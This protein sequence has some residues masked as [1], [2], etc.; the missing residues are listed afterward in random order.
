MVALAKV[1]SRRL[2]R[3]DAFSSE[4]K[5]PFWMVRRLQSRARLDCLAKR[6]FLGESARLRVSPMDGPR[7]ERIRVRARARAGVRGRACGRVRV[8]ACARARVCA[9][10][11]APCDHRER[12]SPTIPGIQGSTSRAAPVGSGS[13]RHQTSAPAAVFQF[14]QHR[15]LIGTRTVPPFSGSPVCGGIKKRCTNAPQGVVQLISR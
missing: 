10:G 4:K 15:V 2:D 11:P 5:A 8:R 9:T 3:S 6:D 1:R 14:L 13:R 12:D 7:N